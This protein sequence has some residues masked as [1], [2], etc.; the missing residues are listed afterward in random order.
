MAGFGWA[1]DSPMLEAEAA[2][3][4]LDYWEL[5]GYIL[6]GEQPIG[7]SQPGRQCPD[8]F[9][10]SSKWVER[11]LKLRPETPLGFSSYGI[12]ANHDIHYVPWIEA[13]A[14]A[15]PQ[16]YGNEFPWMMP[17]AGVLGAMDVR[18]PWNGPPYGWPEDRIHPTFANYKS[19]DKP[20]P[21]PQEYA[22]IAA[23]DE[24]REASPSTSAS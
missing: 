14:R 17:S 6:N 8:C 18:Q 2:D 21:T 22:E 13:G 16:T 10:Y 5:D 1:V 11:W 9:G 24:R 3:R 4:L 15:L 7:Y 20:I 12:F 19:G 23:A